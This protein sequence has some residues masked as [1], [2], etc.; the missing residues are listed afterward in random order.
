MVSVSSL[1]KNKKAPE[2]CQG[3]DSRFDL[4][5]QLQAKRTH[6]TPDSG[7]IETTTHTDCG[8]I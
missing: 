8:V 1:P 4:A 2:R 7:L 5:K 6:P 3:Q